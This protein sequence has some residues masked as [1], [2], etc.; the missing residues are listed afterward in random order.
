MPFL[1]HLEELRWRILWSLLALTLTTIG[2]FFFVF[3]VPVIEFLMTP[4]RPY[5]A[6]GKLAYLAVTDPFVIVIKLALAIGFVL[7]SPIII[8]QAWAFLSPALLPK[9]KRAIVPALYLGVVLF[10]AGA[11]LAY[12][13]GIPLTIDFMLSLQVESLEPNIT[14]GFYFGFVIKMLLA[15]G[16]IFEIPVVVLVLASIGLV[17]SDFLKSKRRYAIAGMAILAAMITPG[18]AITVTVLM[19]GPLLLLYE[20]SIGLARLVERNRERAA[21]AEAAAAEAESAD[22]LP[23]AT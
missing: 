7:A 14:A 10:A 13:V 9:E 19:M 2:A 16:A 15:F 4:I 12:F 23:E 18:D 17:T 3:Y 20:L 21:A 6:E 22:A 1:D 5:L 8:Y 11:A